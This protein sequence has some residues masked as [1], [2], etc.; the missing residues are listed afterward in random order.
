MKYHWTSL[1]FQNGDFLFTKRRR[2]PKLKQRLRWGGL[3][4]S[5]HGFLVVGFYMWLCIKMIGTIP[6]W[7]YRNKRYNQFFVVNFARGSIPVYKNILDITTNRCSSQSHELSC[8]VR[9]CDLMTR[10]KPERRWWCGCQDL[11][12]AWV[13][14]FKCLNVGNHHAS[15]KTIKGPMF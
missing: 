4:W 7:T 5:F 14:Q 13:I 1:N 6:K 11:I 8:T 2:R 10:Q 15:A 12:V 3:R 9:F